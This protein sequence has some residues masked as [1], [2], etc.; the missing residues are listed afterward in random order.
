MKRLLRLAGGGHTPKEMRWH[1]A[2]LT[3][4][5]WGLV[6]LARLGYPAENHYAIT[7]EML[8]AL[9]SFD[10]RYN[11]RWFWLFTLAMTYCGLMMIPVML[12]VRRQ[13]RDLSPIGTF[14]GTIFFIGGCL[15]IFLTGLFPYSRAALWGSWRWADIHVPVAGAI[16]VFFSLGAFWYAALILK[17]RFG[18]KQF[19]PVPFWGYSV[20]FLPYLVCFSVFFILGLKL[21][22]D[23]VYQALQLLFQAELAAASSFVMAAVKPVQSAAILEHISI[24]GLTFFVVF[25]AGVIPDQDGATPEK[26][27]GIRP[28]EGEP[29]VDARS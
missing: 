23:L 7:K 10:A 17:D 3:G 27:T 6:L 8:S 5:F 12:Y 4:G 18:K 24:W 15:S 20:F 21:R 2:C 19:T 9:G 29:Q 16:A 22:W 14:V 25:F 11:P 13:L 28:A 1:L 26:E